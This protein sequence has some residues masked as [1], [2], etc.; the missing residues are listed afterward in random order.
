MAVK[1][2]HQT[3]AGLARPR[4]KKEKRWHRLL[5]RGLLLAAIIGGGTAGWHALGGSDGVTLLAEKGAGRLWQA[6]GRAGYRIE[7]L[8]ADGRVNLPKGALFAALG[9]RQGDPILGFSPAEAKTRLEA[10]PWVEAAHV[11]RRMPDTVY[12]KLIERRPVAVWQAP[13]GPRLIDRDGFVLAVADPAQL[14]DLPALYGAEAFA[15][16]PE[17][18]ADVADRPGLAGLLDTA[19]L[20]Q[21]RRWH[22]R[23]KDGLEIVMPEDDIPGA[24]ARLETLM[25]DLEGKDIVRIDL[26]LPDRAAIRLSPA[27]AEARRVAAAPSKR[28]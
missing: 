5:K 25:P 3:A 9:I 14:P 13:T 27:A 11:E 8:E 28:S 18:L 6:T 15:R 26:T 4:R 10:L 1:T 23:L 21:G 17:L 2:T 16:G 24:L 20:V 7:R 19:L 12:I 22:L